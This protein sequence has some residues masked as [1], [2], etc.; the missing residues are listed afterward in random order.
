[1]NCLQFRKRILIAPRTPSVD[2]IAHR[3]A[4]AQCAAFAARVERMETLLTDAVLVNPPE[5]LAHRILL[6]RSLA[7]SLP[8]VPVRRRLLALAASVAIA[9]TGLGAFLF[10]RHTEEA[11]MDDDLTRELVAHLLMK[12]PPGLANA[13]QRV[14]KADVTGLLQRARF[15]S[16]ESLGRVT[17]AWPCEFRD[18]P[19]AHLVLGDAAGAITALVL[20]EALT[21]QTRHFAGP[22]L[23]GLIAPCAHGTLALLS[24]SATADLDT[25]ATGFQAIIVSA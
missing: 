18:Q 17:N 12:H 11:G 3:D 7:D 13:A 25:I 4:C 10:W 21:T 1:M 15:S 24:E 19:I 22:N 16:R 20:P 14:R 8:A 5:G 6:R 23:S 9:S 2:M